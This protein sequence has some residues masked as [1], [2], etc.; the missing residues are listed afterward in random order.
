MGSKLRAMASNL[1]A[2]ASNLLAMA[3]N[4]EAMA[5]NLKAMASNLIAMAS[6]PTSDGILMFL[7]FKTSVLMEDVPVSG[8]ER[9]GCHVLLTLLYTVAC[10][11]FVYMA[12]NYNSN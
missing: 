8:E 10:L 5:S 9:G 3:S 12:S 2:M 1:L 7:F 6:Q 11:M 4:L